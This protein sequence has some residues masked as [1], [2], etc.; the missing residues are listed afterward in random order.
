VRHTYIGVASILIAW[1]IASHCAHGSAA[2]ELPLQ[3]D[4]VISHVSRTISWYRD[5]AALQQL[6]ADSDDVV[7]RD[8]LHQ[9]A[10]TSLRLA[11]DFGQAA[12]EMA[13]APPATQTGGRANPQATTPGGGNAVDLAAARL[14][15]RVADLQSQLQA[16]DTQLAHASG[17]NKQTLAAK[18]GEIS[19]AL[20]L[21]KEIQ[22][23][24]GQIQRFQQAANVRTGA[25]G[26]GLGA[27]IADLRR[28][29]S[30]VQAAGNDTGKSSQPTSGPPTLG[31]P[32]P[33]PATSETFRPE[34]AGVIALIGRWFSLESGRRQLADAVKQTDGLSKDLEKIR[35]QM[36]QEAR[37]LANQNLD[38]ASTDPAQLAQSKA[39]FQD[40]AAR[41][42]QLSTLLV[43]LGEQAITLDTA[44]SVLDEWRTGLLIRTGT[45]ARYL[46]LRLGLLFGSAAIV[47]V[48]SE[49]W[50]RATFRY[51]HDG[52]RR[53][54]FLALRRMVVG[55]ALTLVVVFG[56]VSEVGSLATYAGLITAGLAVALQ[57]VILAVVAYFFLIGRYGVRIGDRITLAGV[58]GRVVE[59]GL[60]RIY[61]MELTGSQLRASGRMVVLSNAVLFQ[62]TALFK[63]MPGGDFYWHT[64]TVTLAPATAVSTAEERL[65]H[66]ATAVYEQYRPA[67][68]QQHAALQRFID[69][70]TTLPQPEVFVRLTMKGFECTIRYPVEPVQAA[71]T[72]QKM[73]AAIQAA[74]SAAPALDLV[75]GPVL[76][77]KES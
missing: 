58:T 68:E 36:T 24:V 56:L 44:H 51:L 65:N 27:Q 5:I 30:E 26:S 41:F 31:P 15:V 55:L 25:N 33:K 62:P 14:T 11:F 8:R 20:D 40:A 53:Q 17:K 43:P 34:S 70:Q 71:S 22:T 21:A 73:L 66:A 72:D 47:L 7:L 50:R 1:G 54:Q 2:A 37:D 42:K 76:D 46:I 23:T 32:T 16:I 52:R 12:G 19:A 9:T 3:G 29:V 45:V 61:L 49:L 10:Q 6:P 67:I 63:Q 57:N 59:I 13:E 74:H 69:F 28:S 38:V 18:R 39:K 77:T 75:E 64:I 4:Q 60:V 48:V 35:A